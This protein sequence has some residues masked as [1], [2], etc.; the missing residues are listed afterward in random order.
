MLADDGSSL[1]ETESGKPFIVISL[2]QADFW[3]RN[4]SQANLVRGVLSYLSLQ[5]RLGKDPGNEV[6]CKLLFICLFRLYL[7]LYPHTLII[8]IMLHRGVDLFSLQ[9]T[10]VE[11]QF[12]R[13]A[14]A[15]VG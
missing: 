6:V 5:G 11:T 7:R 8:S 1:I 15:R 2:N 12:L 13:K 10:G 14:K 9:N 3:W 4:Y